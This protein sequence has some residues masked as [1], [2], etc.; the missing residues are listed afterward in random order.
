M[1]WREPEIPERFRKAY[2]RG[3][4]GKAKDAIRA[5]CAM[6]CGWDT[7]EVEKCTAIGCPLYNL[8]NRAAQAAIEAPVRVKQRQRMIESGMR[9]PNRARVDGNGTHVEGQIANATDAVATTLQG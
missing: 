9:P 3:R 4:A 8:R 1:N 5:M 6:C 7:S 2:D